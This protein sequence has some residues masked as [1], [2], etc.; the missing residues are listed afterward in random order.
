MAKGLNIE[1]ER[2][3][4]AVL[5]VVVMVF[6]LGA[7]AQA[8]SFAGKVLALG[9]GL[10]V[11]Q[12]MVTVT[13]EPGTV[14]PHAVTV[15]TDEAGTFTFPDDLPPLEN[16]LSIHAK[17]LGFSKARKDGRALGHAAEE[18]SGMTLYLDAAANIASQVPA[19]AW[20]DAAEPGRARNITVTSC[21]SC[22]QLASPRMREYAAQIEAVRGG[23]E[24]TGRALEAWR[25]VVRHEAWRTIVK[26]MRSMHYSV[27][28]LESKMNI[29]AVDWKTAQD[30]RLNFFNAEQGETIAQYLADHFPRTTDYLPVGDYEYGAELGVTGRTVIREYTFPDEALV[31]EL[32][33]VPDTDY[34]WGADVKR[35]KIVRLDPA[36]G[37]TRWYAVDFNGSTGPHTIVSD[38]KGSLWVSMIDND[39][40]GHFDPKTEK[41]DLW[42]LRPVNLPNADSIAGAAIVHDM[43]IDSHGHLARDRFGKIWLTIVGTNQMGTLEPE[44][45]RVAFYDTNRIEGLSPIN[46]LLYSTVLSPD[47]SCAWYSQVNGW[48]GCVDTDTKE[49]RNEIPFPEGTGPR[50]MARDDDGTLWVAL[51]GTGQVARIDMATA[52]VS[53]T[54]DLPDRASAPYAVTW[55]G[56]RK[57]VWVANANSDALNRLDP[58]TGEVTVYPLPRPMAYLRKVEVDRDG[59]L[60]ASYGNYPEGSGPSMGVLID[61][62]D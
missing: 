8:A 6:C 62:G 11:A 58:E 36:T 26:Y 4:L 10:P 32:V 19:S 50:R 38:D 42:T 20:L 48:V 39:Q 30:T 24:G 37:E 17:K 16:A 40:F 28:P 13:F 57:A 49:I 60:V 23:P 5:T 12:A 1:K 46:H 35:N 31:R 7:H 34:L 47:G 15:F 21:S 41:W 18:K 9:D 2:R 43:S 14:G 45:G 22:H 25:K 61:V 59:R 54:Y 55:D 44:T 56:R 52:K 29:G 33:P 51:F 53:A 3:F 27:F